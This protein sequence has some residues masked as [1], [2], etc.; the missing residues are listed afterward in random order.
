MMAYVN[1][2]GKQYSSRINRC[3]KAQ[4][5]NLLMVKLSCKAE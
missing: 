2:K 4:S 1:S 3:E 5:R